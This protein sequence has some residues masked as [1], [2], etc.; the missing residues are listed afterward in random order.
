MKYIPQV[1]AK[2]IKVKYAKEQAT[3]RSIARA[4]PKLRPFCRLIFPHCPPPP[5]GA[6]SPT[7]PHFVHQRGVRNI[8]NLFR[9]DRESSSLAQ[10]NGTFLD[11]HC[12]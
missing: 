2:I 1:G 10:D 5:T 4:G 11:H 6:V 7:F 12:Y 8:K 3:A 9:G